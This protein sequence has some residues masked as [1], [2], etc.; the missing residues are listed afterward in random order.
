MVAL[1][2]RKLIPHLIVP[3]IVPA[4]DFYK[5]AFGGLE[6]VPIEPESGDP[7][8]GVELRIGSAVFYVGEFLPE[9]GGGPEWEQCSQGAV[10]LHLEVEDCDTVWARAVAAGAEVVCPPQDMFWGDRY[11]RIRDPFGHEWSFSH[12]AAPRQ[13]SAA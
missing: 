6:V 10:T 12:S 4:V 3:A 8:N 2:R 7:G 5:R 9:K 13:R 11:A 1:Q